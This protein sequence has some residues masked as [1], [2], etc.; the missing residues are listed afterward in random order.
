MIC[1]GIGMDVIFCWSRQYYF[2]P[3][4]SEHKQ[5]APTPKPIWRIQ[6][7]PNPR[8][9]N[10]HV[11]QSQGSQRTKQCWQCCEGQSHLRQRWLLKVPVDTLQRNAKKV[12][13][14]KIEQKASNPDLSKCHLGHVTMKILESKVSFW[15][16]HHDSI[17]LSTTSTGCPSHRFHRGF[18]LLMQQLCGRAP[19]TT[20]NHQVAWLCEGPPREFV[21]WNSSKPLGTVGKSLGICISYSLKH[22]LRKKK[23]LPCMKLKW[24]I[25]HLYLQATFAASIWPVFTRPARQVLDVAISSFLNKNV[26]IMYWCKGN[27]KRCLAH[28]CLHTC[29]VVRINHNMLTA[30]S[31]FW[32]LGSQADT[33]NSSQ[34]VPSCCVA[35]VGGIKMGGCNWKVGLAGTWKPGMPR[36]QWQPTFLPQRMTYDDMHAPGWER[37]ATSSSQSNDGNHQYFCNQI[38]RI[39]RRMDTINVNHPWKDISWYSICDQWIPDGIFLERHLENER[40]FPLTGSRLWKSW[41]LHPASD[42]VPSRQKLWVPTESTNALGFRHRSVFCL[43][44][45]PCE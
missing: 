9:I 36:S 13:P 37:G 5:I 42:D 17:D 7:G 34:V 38:G 21:T 44:Q 10:F 31:C 16:F 20:S 25:P 41:Y 39:S 29:R 14:Q 15:S 30:L 43:K 12:S 24:T 26:Y 33:E 28:T 11:A 18:F 3:S 2:K 8:V 23:P 45:I 6:L 40:V 19:V 22:V 4:V 27:G 1:L 35:I 32:Q